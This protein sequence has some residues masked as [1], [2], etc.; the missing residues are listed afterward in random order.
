MINSNKRID[1]LPVELKRANLTLLKNHKRRRES[2]YS[3]Y[4]AHNM[5]TN[6]FLIKNTLSIHLFFFS[7]SNKYTK[8]VFFLFV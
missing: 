7:L 2:I 5:R 3:T 4:L 1:L 8:I 6:F